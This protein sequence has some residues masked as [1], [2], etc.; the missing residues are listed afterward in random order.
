MQSNGTPTVRHITFLVTAVASLFLLVAPQVLGDNTSYTQTNLV[1]DVPGLAPSLDPNLKNPWGMAS[2]SGSPNWVSDQGTGLATIYTGSG[3]IAALVVTIPQTQ[4]GTPSSPT[5]VVFNATSDFNGAHFIFATLG[6]T[7]AAWT[8]GTSAVTSASVFD[9]VFTGLA[10]GNNGSGN[11]LYAA[12][13]KGGRI[14][15]FDGNFNPAALH[16]NFI[17]PNLPAGYSPYNIQNVGGKLYVEYVPVSNGR[18]LAGTGN[19]L[20]DV[21]DTNGNFLER[22]TTGGPLND[23]WGVALA[24]A[25]FGAFG[26]DLLV[27][28]FGNGQI[29]AF[30]PTTGASLGT[31]DNAQGQPIVNDGLWALHF[32]NGGNGGNADTLFFNAGIN[33]QQDGL[34]GSIDAAGAVSTPEPPTAYVLVFGIVALGLLRLRSRMAC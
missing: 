5:G 34:Y 24:P 26:S 29:N 31:L 30:D 16:G 22:L 6:G 33:N 11:F 18:P 20:V 19:G 7:I 27:G 14:D 21:F 32:G 8:S 10:Q 3:N 1:S 4:I 13:F 17:D 25:G 2:S 23:P 28:N 9:A 15:V 12:D